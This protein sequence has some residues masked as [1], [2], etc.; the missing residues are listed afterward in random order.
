MIFSAVDPSQL[1]KNVVFVLS[2]FQNPLRAKLR[3]KET[4]M[5]ATYNDDWDENC[6]HLM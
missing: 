3:N 4:K 5:G 1:M 2:D 6:T